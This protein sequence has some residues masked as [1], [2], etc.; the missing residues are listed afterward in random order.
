MKIANV[1]PA[2]NDM[3]DPVG[4]LRE[5]KNRNKIVKIPFGFILNNNANRKKTTNDRTCFEI[6]NRSTS[7]Y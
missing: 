1:K 3:T 7:C 6:S 5:K 4:E 2:A